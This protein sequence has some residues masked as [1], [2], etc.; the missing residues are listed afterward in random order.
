MYHIS[1]RLTNIYYY[2]PTKLF[3]VF[4]HLYQL[5]F[6][7]I[8]VLTV[9]CHHGYTFYLAVLDILSY[10][11][12][13]WHNLKSFERFKSLRTPLRFRTQD[14]VWQ[15]TFKWNQAFGHCDIYTQ[16]SPISSQ[17]NICSVFPKKDIFTPFVCSSR[18]YLRPKLNF[19]F[20]SFVS[21][22]TKY[23][24]VYYYCIKVKLHAKQ[25]LHGIL[26]NCGYFW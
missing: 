4:N 25:N 22:T 15:I 12:F 26:I 7:M 3:K 2:W 5:L 18:Y 20:F 11:V 21:I 13:N 23:I 16:S 14:P 10:T 24:V 6:C 9:F 8:G 1:F 19:Y 17:T